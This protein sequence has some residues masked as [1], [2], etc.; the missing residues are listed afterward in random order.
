MSNVFNIS[1]TAAEI[2]HVVPDVVTLQEVDNMTQR[3][4]VDE[5]AYLSSHTN[6]R[7]TAFAP[8]R[9]FQ[10]GQYGIAILSR[11]PI[12]EVR[13]HQYEKPT[14]FGELRMASDCVDQKPMDF[15]QGILAIK[16]STSAFPKGLW[17]VTT[18]IS[19]DG[20]QSE[21]ARQ[22]VS[23]VNDLV[24][25]TNVPDAL[26]TGDFNEAPNGKGPSHLAKYWKDTF[27]ICYNHNKENPHGYTFNSATP[28]RRIDYIW[29]TNPQLAQCKRAF[30]VFTQAS[31]HLPYI[32]DWN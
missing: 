25:K 16:I 30:T 5:V 14:N 23:Y 1:G 28:D 17:V 21:E 24:S 3:H 31:D 27:G 18:H 6:M 9:P 8:W 7:Y 19:A 32:A 26:V 13:K 29:A 10:G 20:A 2:N 11:H 22:L 15:C 12:I 4:P